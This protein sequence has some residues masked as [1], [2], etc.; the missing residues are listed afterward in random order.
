MTAP[1]S[2]AHA[3]FAERSRPQQA[4]ELKGQ[5]AFWREGSVL[6]Q[7]VHRGQ[8]HS[9]IFW[10]PPGTGKTS[11]ARLVGDLAGLGF[12]P[13]SAVQHGVKEI[14]QEIS[15]SEILC[16]HGEKPLLLFMDEIHRLSKA[17]QDVLLPAIESG[18]IKLVGATTENPSF[19]VNNAILSRSLV[20]H[21]NKLSDEALVAIVQQALAKHGRQQNIQE[22]VLSRMIQY[23]DGD[24]RRALTLVDA[25][26][27]SIPADQELTEDHVRE[28]AKDLAINYDQQGEYHY[29]TISAFIKSMRA[30]HPDAALHYLARML[31][32][33]EDALFIARRLVIFAS[34]DCGNA[35]PTALLVATSGMQAVHM[36]GMPEAR[37]ILSQ[38]TTYLSASPKSNASYNAINAAWDD[39]RRL[40]E[41]EVPKHLRNAPTEL[42]K[43]EGYG[44]GYIYPHDDIKGAK[45]L[46]YL[47]KALK[48]KRYYQ[49]RDIGAEKQIRENLERLRPQS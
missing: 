43:D 44:K 15:R 42:M 12:V 26:L 19:R 2:T 23:A 20:F 46:E 47:P 1:K 29:D 3:P 8:F 21:F 28:L 14:R 16:N 32:S 6:W 17:Q 34:E 30:S 10:G 22:S 41:L 11:L 35:N 27:E 48:G 36:I 40:G 5:E 25:L 49:P 24:A 4:H 7:M 39:V 31:E 45:T 13:M 38:M 18:V 9:L 33:G 37:I